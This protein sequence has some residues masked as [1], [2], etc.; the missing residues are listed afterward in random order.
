MGINIFTKSAYAHPETSKPETG[1][2]EPCFPDPNGYTPICRIQYRSKLAAC[3]PKAD[4]SRTLM[5]M[6]MMMVVLL[7]SPEENTIA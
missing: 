6:M 2:T 7:M 5:M 4:T 1:S 3:Q